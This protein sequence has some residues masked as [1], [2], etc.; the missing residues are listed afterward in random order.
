MGRPPNITREA[1]PAG[2]SA[3]PP[4]AAAAEAPPTPTQDMTLDLDLR[5]WHQLKILAERKAVPVHDLIIEAIHDF[6]EKNGGPLID[7]AFL[8]V[9]ES[10]TLPE[11]DRSGAVPTAAMPPPVAPRGSPGRPMDEEEKV[12]AGRAD[13]NM[14]AL[15]TRD[16]PGG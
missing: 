6:F 5:I 13:A 2:H 12:L 16:V 8:P 14:P 10:T 9:M 15:L 7:A 1:R 3:T 11:H 4:L